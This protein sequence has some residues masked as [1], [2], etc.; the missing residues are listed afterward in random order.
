MIYCDIESSL[1]FKGPET[2]ISG[3]LRFQPLFPATPFRRFT[4]N[5]VQIFINIDDIW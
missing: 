4:G 1:V 2:T 5:P 3:L